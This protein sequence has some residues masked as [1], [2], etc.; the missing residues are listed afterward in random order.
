MSRL[1]F[2]ESTQRLRSPRPRFNPR[3]AVRKAQSWA[4]ETIL[5]TAAVATVVFSFIWFA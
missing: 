3:A 1:R 2:A 5:L 4:G